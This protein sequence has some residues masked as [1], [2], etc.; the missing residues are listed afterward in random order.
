MK[1]HIRR[2]AGSPSSA[3]YGMGFIGSAIYF[4]Q[5]ASSFW[6]GAL[7]ILKAIVWPAILT[8]KAFGLLNM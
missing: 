1:E 4:I 6:M 8:Y 5:H 3:V 2:N 7:G